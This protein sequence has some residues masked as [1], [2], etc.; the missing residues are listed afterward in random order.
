MKRLFSFSFLVFS[1]LAGAALTQ[2]GPLKIEI[3]DGVIEPLSFAVPVFEAENP[4]AREIAVSYT[5]LTLPTRIR[6]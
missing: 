1:C 6:V 4:A 2:D 3:T 5:H